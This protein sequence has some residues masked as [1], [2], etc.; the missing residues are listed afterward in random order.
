MEKIKP[1][2]KDKNIT[3]TL[4]VGFFASPVFYSINIIPEEYVSLYLLINPIA[5]ILENIRLALNNEININFFL[6]FQSWSLTIILL[7]IGI[8]IFVSQHEKLIER[9]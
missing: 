8:R 9:L 2:L 7:F 6:M 3:Y 4:Y 1:K 5:P